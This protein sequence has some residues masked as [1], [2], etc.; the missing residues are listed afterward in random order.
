MSEIC[1]HCLD[2]DLSGF[3]ETNKGRH[4]K[5]CKTLHPYPKVKPKPQKQTRIS[6]LPVPVA[7]TP[8]PLV[9]DFVIETEVVEVDVDEDPL[10]AAEETESV[11]VDIQNDPPDDPLDDSAKEHAEA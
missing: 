3:N 8:A 7:P 4:L 1:P 5:K 9:D 11:D 10:V 6:F 2:K